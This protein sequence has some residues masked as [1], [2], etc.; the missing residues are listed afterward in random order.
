MCS[1]ESYVVGRKEGRKEGGKKERGRE[2]ERKKGRRKGIYICCIYA[3]LS[4]KKVVEGH[5][6]N[7]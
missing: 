1:V 6:P 3:C 4:Q 5:P 7:R 2:G